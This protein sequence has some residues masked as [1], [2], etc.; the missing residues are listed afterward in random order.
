M[1]PRILWSCLDVLHCELYWLV[2]IRSRHG[3]TLDVDEAAVYGKMRLWLLGIRRRSLLAGDGSLDIRGL[4]CEEAI[5]SSD[6][7]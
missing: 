5:I 3:I 1:L 4:V 6:L 7:E 2:E